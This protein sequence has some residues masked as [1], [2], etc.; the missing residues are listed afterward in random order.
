MK[1]MVLV[2]GFPGGSVAKNLPTS[3]GDAGDWV[4]FLDLENPLGEEMATHSSILAWI[5]QWTDPTSRWVTK[6]LMTSLDSSSTFSDP[7]KSWM[8]KSSS[9]RHSWWWLKP[10]AKQRQCLLRPST[11]CFVSIS[12]I[13]A[14]IIMNSLFLLTLV[15]IYSSFSSCFRYKLRSFIG[16]FSCLLR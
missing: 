15:F 4:G 10:H 11:V 6:L 14:L 3:A 2:G 9:K 13:S 1:V 8:G 16:D 12:F 5:I 7:W